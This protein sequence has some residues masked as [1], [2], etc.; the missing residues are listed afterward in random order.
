MTPRP[1]DVGLRLRLIRPTGNPKGEREVRVKWPTPQE[2][3]CGTPAFL[4]PVPWHELRNRHRPGG[5]RTDPDRV[6]DLLRL[7]HAFRRGPQP[8]HLPGVH[9]LSG[10]ASSVEPQGGGA[11][12]PHRAGHPLHYRPEQPLGAQELLLSGSPQ[13]LPDQPVRAAVV[14]R[15]LRGREPRRRLETGS[16]DPHPH[17][18]G[19]RQEHPRRA[20]RPQPGGPQPGGRFRSWR[21]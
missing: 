13:G 21:S 20:R 4:L 15:G 2:R 1:S 14:H 3:D 10:G 18:G 5:A 12:H 9:G 11:H 19:R 8:Q 16:A 17:G 6:E 7:F